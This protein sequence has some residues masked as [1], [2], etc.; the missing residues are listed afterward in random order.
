MPLRFERRQK[1]AR[2]LD[3]RAEFQETLVP[4]E[5]RRDP[6]TGHSGRVAHFVGFHVQPPDF[7]EQIELSRTN[8]PFC[9]D[10]VLNV[11][12]RFPAEL[13]AEGRVQRG[14][15]VLFPNLSPYDEHSAVAALSREHYVPITGFTSQLL[16]DG[17]EASAAYFRALA[18]LP[19]TDYG[20]LMWNYL[21]ASGGTQIHPH[22]QLFATDTPGNTLEREAV[23]AADYY[24][25]E[26]RNYWDDLLR[27]E[28]RLGE[29]FIAR[30]QHCAWLASFISQS[31]LADTLI[32]FPGK[33]TLSDL[34]GEALDELSLGLTQALAAFAA[35]GIYSFNLATFPATPGRDDAWLR[36]RLSPRLYLVPRLW[37]PDTSTLQ[38]LY[39]EHYMVQSPEESAAQL[40]STIR[41]P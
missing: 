25:R 16:R 10:R 37:A 2:Y 15:T 39:G 8:C 21:P 30:G 4:C 12:P 5:L 38:H 32:V 36:L 33:R 14:E 40:R 11:T 27:E 19:G 26:R 20:L 9:P 28:E 29:R 7:T 41:L 24:A 18:A 23:A 3:P 31:M 22:F 6:L 1:T 13:V 34:P 17:F 35:Q